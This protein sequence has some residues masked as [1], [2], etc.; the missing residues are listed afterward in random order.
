MSLNELLILTECHMQVADAP[1]NILFFYISYFSQRI[2]AAYVTPTNV[3]NSMWFT[4]HTTAREVFITQNDR[5]WHLSI[6]ELS[7]SRQNKLHGVKPFFR[8]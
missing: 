6:N 7:Y 1:H 3:I 5:H 4:Y 2:T 8:S